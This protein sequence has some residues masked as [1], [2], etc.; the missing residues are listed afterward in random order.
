MLPHSSFIFPHF[1]R[2]QR[3]TT[4]TSIWGGYIEADGMESTRDGC[5]FVRCILVLSTP[6]LSTLYL[7]II[8]H[9]YLHPFPLSSSPIHPPPSLLHHSNAFTSPPS[10][11]I[12]SPPRHYPLPLTLS[13]NFHIHSL[14][15]H[16]FPPLHPSPQSTSSINSSFITSDFFP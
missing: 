2:N 3:Y 12:H 5:I 7:S 10:S 6:R 16:P 14:Y 15:T 13:T 11:F 8:I 9:T 1:L 4:R